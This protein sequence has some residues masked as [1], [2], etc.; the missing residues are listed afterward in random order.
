MSVEFPILGGGSGGGGA[1]IFTQIRNGTKTT[2]VSTDDLSILTNYNHQYLF[3]GITTITSVD[4]AY[5]SASTNMQYVLAFCTGLTYFKG[6]LAGTSIQY[7][8]NGDTALASVEINFDGWDAGNNSA[9]AVF[10]GCSSLLT[11]VVTGANTANSIGWGSNFSVFSSASGIMSVTSL[12]FNCSIIHST[13]LT[14]CTSINF[15]SILNILT[16][17]Y[18]YSGGTARTITFSRTMAD[19]DDILQ[20]AVDVANARNWTVSGLT[21]T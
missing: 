17:L 2:I 14:A 3:Y 20:D 1:D 13:V 6:H 19:P 4:T 15:A 21:L 9:R 16:Q 18:D 8:F 10:G 5:F 12:T 7:A 11:I